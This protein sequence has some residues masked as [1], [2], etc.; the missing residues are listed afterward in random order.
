MFELQLKSGT[1][2][3]YIYF[4]F[5]KNLTQFIIFNL[6]VKNQNKSIS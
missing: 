5:L 4:Y 1:K 2:Y 6:N 3:I